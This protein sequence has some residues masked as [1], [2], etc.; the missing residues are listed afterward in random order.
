MR[1]RV[2][3]L[4]I[5]ALS[6]KSPDFFPSL[7]IALSRPNY[8]DLLD[9]KAEWSGPRD[10]WTQGAG[11]KGTKDAKFERYDGS[12]ELGWMQREMGVVG[13]QGFD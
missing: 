9:P 7:A 10:A 13:L 11:P 2:R 8:P 12:E 6:P 4:L 3:S 1:C 5:A